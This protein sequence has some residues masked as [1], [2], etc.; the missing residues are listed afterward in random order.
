M[1]EQIKEVK[2][3][4]SELKDMKKNIEAKWKSEETGYIK[5]IDEQKKE[6][7]NINE[8]NNH[9]AHLLKDRIK[10]LE[11]TLTSRKT[12][13]NNMRNDFDKTRNELKDT[14]AQLDLIT[15]KAEETKILLEG[16]SKCS[17]WAQ[18][19]SDFQN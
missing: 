8:L 15:K 1:N 10:N 11:N 19:L 9:S 5:K 18:F 6:M 7:C 14:K 13:E 17:L 4:C 12:H 16:F 3:E 2:S